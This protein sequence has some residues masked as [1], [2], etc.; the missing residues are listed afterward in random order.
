MSPQ[1]ALPLCSVVESPI[2]LGDRM[3]ELSESEFVTMHSKAQ[4]MLPK[5]SSAHQSEARR[6]QIKYPSKDNESW[7][8]NLQSYPQSMT[9]CKTPFVLETLGLWT[10]SITCIPASWIS[11]LFVWEGTPLSP[12]NVHRE[13]KTAMFFWSRQPKALTPVSHHINS[14]KETSHGADFMPL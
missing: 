2:L 12:E 7:G 3:F 6:G 4:K 14:L 10:Q 11:M 13:T 8:E 9:A 1:G 5:Q